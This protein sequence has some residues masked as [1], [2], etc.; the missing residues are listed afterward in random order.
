[1]FAVFDCGFQARSALEVDDGSQV[2]FEK[3]V[4]LIADCQYGIH[5]IS[6]IEL[7]TK[8]G[9]PR[10]NMPLEL[11]LFL[12]AKRY[13]GARQKQKKCLILEA[14]KFRY[15]QLMSDISGQ[16]IRA[17]RNEPETAV[18]LIRN[19]LRTAA[20]DTALPGGATIWRRYKAFRRA[21]PAMCRRLRLTA[22]DLT[23]VDYEWLVSEWLK[24][25]T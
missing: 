7:D 2:R 10:F 21:L 23:F 14:E 3:I 8:S 24:A 13:G 6:R 15:Q 1:M 22:G 9:L 25:N 5:D 12:G 17:H 11:G 20:P 16:D 4:G 18:G 19:W